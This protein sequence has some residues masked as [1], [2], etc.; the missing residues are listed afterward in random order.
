[1]SE[2]FHRPDLAQKMAIQLIEQGDQVRVGAR[3][4]D[5]KAGIDTEHLAALLDVDRV[6]VPSQSRSRLK[7]RH[8]V[9]LRKKMRRGQPGD[10]RADHRDALP[11]KVMDVRIAPS[12]GVNTLIRCCGRAAAP[13]IPAANWHP[14]GTRRASRC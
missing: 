2:I 8:G 10:T 4:E 14:S 11:K 13:G 9:T 6:R 12:V 1:M 3:I 7:Q 5:E